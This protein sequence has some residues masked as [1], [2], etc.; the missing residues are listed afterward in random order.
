MGFLVMGP[1]ILELGLPVCL[2]PFPQSQL[3]TSETPSISVLKKTLSQILSI[4]KVCIF[5]TTLGLE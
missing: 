1:K 3:V 5:F 4:Q 2:P